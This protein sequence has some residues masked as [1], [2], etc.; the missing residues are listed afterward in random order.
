MG[1]FPPL[2]NIASGRTLP[3]ARLDLARRI[4]PPLLQ[5]GLPLP[6]SPG[7]SPDPE[8]MADGLAQHCSSREGDWALVGLFN[9]SGRGDARAVNP[10]P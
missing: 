9:W 2:I 10:E 5:G 7:S 8:D 1:R 6:V 3:A 4:F